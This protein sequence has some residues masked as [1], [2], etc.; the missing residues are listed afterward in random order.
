MAHPPDLAARI[1][2]L[3]WFHQ[4]DFGDGLLSPGWVKKSKIERAK[5]LFFDR[6]LEG[7]SVLD[8]GCWDGAYS[9]AAAQMGAARVV[10]SDW[11]VWN[12][13]IGDKRAFELARA[14]LAPNI[15]LVEAP[16]EELTVDRLGGPF[17]IVLFAGVFYHIPHPTPLLEHVSKLVREVLVFESRLCGIAGQLTS[18]PLMRFYPRGKLDSDDTNYWAP[19]PA[20]MQALC[21]QIGFK[22]VRFQR[23]DRRFRRGLVHAEW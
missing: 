12:N 15:E 18:K 9:I 19:N 20:C 5:R 8:I 3:H 10:A 16:V 21:R 1:N 17:D 6:P 22:R 23:P 11:F 4:I 2:E 14:T 7:K 13:G